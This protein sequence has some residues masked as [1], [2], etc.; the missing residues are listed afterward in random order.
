[1]RKGKERTIFDNYDFD[2]DQSRES[3][4]EFWGEAYGWESA[5]DIPDEEVYRYMQEQEDMD[6]EDE[7]SR[8]EN[9]FGNGTFLLMGTVGRWDGPAEGGFIFSSFNEL[10]KA[11]KDCD[12]I[13]LYDVNGH[14]MIKCSH[15]DGTNYF[16]VKELTQSGKEYADR[17]DWDMSARELHTRLWK[18]SRYSRL[19]HYAHRVFGCKKTEYAP[20]QKSA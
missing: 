16:E 17:H 14:F 10:C 9:F 6:W 4:L 15:H 13:R 1:M 7:K 8:M 3:A 12:Y 11:W 5:D 20:E 19:L 18:H 2:F